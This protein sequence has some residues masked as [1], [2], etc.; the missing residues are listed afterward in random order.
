MAMANCIKSHVIL[1]L[2]GTLVNTGDYGLPLIASLH[3][4]SYLIS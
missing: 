3:R 4:L 1:D 2:D